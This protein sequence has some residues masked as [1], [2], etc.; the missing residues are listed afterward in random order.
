MKPVIKKAN[1]KIND[2]VKLKNDT[3]DTAYSEMSTTVRYFHL[4]LY[5]FTNISDRHRA[6]NDNLRMFALHLNHLN[7]Y[8]AM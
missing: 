2:Q 8:W 1:E 4:I 3:N 6:G 7:T 5:T